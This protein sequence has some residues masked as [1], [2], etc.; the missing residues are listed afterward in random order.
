MNARYNKGRRNEYRLMRLLETAGYICLRTAGSHSPFD[1]VG[2]GPA[3]VILAQCKTNKWPTPAEWETL[4]NFPT[5]SPVEKLVY[6]FDD[7]RKLPVLK[8][9]GEESEVN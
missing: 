8:R 9:V 7:G 4:R 3:G 1:V 6:R 5:P 2:V